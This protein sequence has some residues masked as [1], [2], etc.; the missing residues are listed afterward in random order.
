MPKSI[1]YTL[2]AETVLTERNLV[3]AWVERTVN[4]PEWRIS[5]SRGDSAERRFRAIPER[6]GRVLRV[7][8]VETATEIR[9]ISVFL[10]RRARRP[11]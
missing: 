7:I 11:E 2:H 10:D 5:D 8:C 3:K 6:Q 9:I 1:R 4:E